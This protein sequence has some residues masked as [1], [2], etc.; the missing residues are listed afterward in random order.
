MIQDAYYFL[1]LNL[2]YRNGHQDEIH[3]VGFSRGA[4]AVRA[5]ACFIRDVGILSRTHLALLPMLYA[6]WRKQDLEQLESH[7]P[8]WESKGHLRRNVQIE[9]CGVWDTV[10]AMIP[11][12]DLAFVNRTVPTN[13]QYAFHAIS[14]HETRTSFLPVLWNTEDPQRIQRTL[15]KQCWLPGD[16]SDIGGG[17][18]DAGM[19]AISLLWMVAQYKEY[20]TACI[21][22]LALLDCMTPLFLHWQEKAF[23]NWEE[24]TLFN[25]EEYLM[26]SHVFTKGTFVIP[27]FDC[28]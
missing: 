16:H 7:T 19:A 23:L 14:L 9:S 4:F 15:V 21:T 1:C 8:A 28:C 20:T 11:A 26:Q 2:G 12:S 22:D 17:H 5:L 10:S 13:L 18:P 6:L 3:L 25:K 27:H 24:M